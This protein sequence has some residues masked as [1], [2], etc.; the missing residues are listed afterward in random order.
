M[1]VKE[2]FNYISLSNYGPLEI[3]IFILLF[4]FSIFLLGSFI[5]RNLRKKKLLEMQEAG[6]KFGEELSSN[7][8]DMRHNRM[9]GLEGGEIID[10]NELLGSSNSLTRLNSFGEIISEEEVTDY[11]LPEY[12]RVLSKSIVKGSEQRWY[13]KEGKE[14][15]DLQS[16][17]GEM[18]SLSLSAQHP[19]A[20]ALQDY[21]NYLN[22]KGLLKFD[23]DEKIIVRSATFP[24]VEHEGDFWWY[25]GAAMQQDNGTTVILIHDELPNNVRIATTLHELIHGMTGSQEEQFVQL[26]T[27]KTLKIMAD[28]FG[29]LSKSDYSK[30]E[31]LDEDFVDFS[32]QSSKDLRE[33]ANYAIKSGKDAYF[34]CISYSDI[35][36]KLRE[37]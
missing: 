36:K 20:T 1:N 19:I 11:S 12:N 6:I 37:T 16:P 8:E 33:A 17:T 26:E 35:K 21:I 32:K 24:F 28:N 18:I 7:K 13:L 15:F 10:V 14:Y 3:I 9:T 4:L 34:D 27:I 22:Q 2:I 25:S 30:F 5:F 31:A 29:S 23:V